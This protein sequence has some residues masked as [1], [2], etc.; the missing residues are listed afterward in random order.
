GPTMTPR[1]EPIAPA[2]LTP[3]AARLSPDDWLILKTL[4]IVHLATTS[5]LQRLTLDRQPVRT[6]EILTAQRLHRLR[7]L[8]LT[9]AFL[10]RPSDRRPGRP[11]YLHTL[12]A[13][14]PTLASA[15]DAL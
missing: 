14:G 13:A 7:R 5:Q 15:P 3:V 1:S 9:S 8:G 2:R 10:R 4:A 6:A 12:T 11:S